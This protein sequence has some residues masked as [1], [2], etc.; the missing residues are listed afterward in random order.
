MRAA[1]FLLALSALCAHAKLSPLAPAPDWSRLDA[2]QE[3]IT[4][5]DFLDLLERVYAPGGAWKDSIQVG[6]SSAK[7]KTASGSWELR[8]APSRD[9]VKAIPGF[10]RGRASLPPSPDPSKPLAG[11]HIAIDPGH[12]GGSWAKMEE[13]WFRMGNG[14]PVQEG[15]MTLLVAKKLKTRLEAMGA[16]VTLT[17]TK[18]APATS[19]RPDKLRKQAL[20]SLA[21]KGKPAT[22]LAVRKES[23]LLFYRTAEIRA[24]S[25]A[26]NGQIRP[27]AVV[28]LHFNAEDWGSETNPKLIEDEHLHFLITGAWSADELAYD[29]HRFDMLSKLLGRT[30]TEEL[31][32]T[33]SISRPVAASTKLPPYT[34]NS[35]AAVRVDTNPYIWARNLLANRLFQCPVVYVEPYLMNGKTTYARIQA[36]D[37]DGT[38]TIRGVP[39]KSIYSEY[40]DAVAAGIA[41][42]YGKR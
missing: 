38:K 8:F 6:D 30:F 28:C 23:E 10:W 29:D 27:D 41:A 22:A 39:R 14:K 7:V 26:V 17:R 11:L 19:L 15:D 1:L 32:L 20:A 33:N 5:E 21:E 36:G 13:R 31:A 24:R 18:A 35:S 3:T 40:A 9:A 25:R 34:Y 12:L 16:K 4:R 42:Y 2:Y 37:Y